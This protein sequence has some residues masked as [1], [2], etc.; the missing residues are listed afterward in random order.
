MVNEQ[1]ISFVSKVPYLSK[2][3][4]AIPRPMAKS[5]PDWWKVKEFDKDPDF[6]DLK[7][8]KHCASFPE[9]FSQ[10]YYLP[11]WADTILTYS[12]ETEQWSWQTPDKTFSWEFHSSSQFVDI[13]RPKVTGSEGYAVFKALSPWS[14]FTPN[15]YSVLQLPMFYNFNEDFTVLPGIIATDVTH[16][17]NLQFLM[18]SSKEEVFIERGT[19]IAQYLPFKRN[20]KL[21]LEVRDATESDLEKI[22]ISNIQYNTRLSRGKE[23]LDKK[24]KIDKEVLNNE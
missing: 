18:H 4:D 9:Y 17:L 1:N 12:K 3:E 21:P 5:I 7:N 19:P 14:V 8:I 10:G 16:T 23:Y 24:K 20:D 22:N 15:G 11:M 2:V 6:E 13:S